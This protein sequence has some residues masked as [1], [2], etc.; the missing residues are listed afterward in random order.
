MGECSRLNLLEQP[1]KELKFV[2]MCEVHNTN[3]V[4]LYFTVVFYYFLW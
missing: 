1:I 4:S 2:E 3:K